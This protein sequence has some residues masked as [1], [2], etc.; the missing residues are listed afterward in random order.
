MGETAH[1]NEALING[2]E[3]TNFGPARAAALAT[4]WVPDDKSDFKNVQQ[5]IYSTN[6]GN[7]TKL[8]D[9]NLRKEE[10]S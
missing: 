6:D 8:E 10:A 3:L 1:I 7:K 4:V 5:V 9:S 2:A